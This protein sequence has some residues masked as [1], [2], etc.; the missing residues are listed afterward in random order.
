MTGRP[1]LIPRNAAA[2]RRMSTAN[3]A[4][5]QVSGNPVS[6]RLESGVGNCYPGLE[7]DL[8]NLER[9]FFP[10]LEVDI[11][12]RAIL[13]VA[14]DLPGVRG[15]EQAGRLSPEA[16]QA[17][18]RIATDLSAGVQWSVATLTG[19]FGELGDLTLRIAGLSGP[20][21]GPG[22]RPPDAWV[23]VR[24]LTEGSQVVLDLRR[25]AQRLRLAGARM[26]Y[27][28]DNGAL[29]P[30]FAPGELT[31][32]LCSPWT[33]DFRDCA[34]YYW[35]SNHPDIAR[36]PLPSPTPQK[37][38]WNDEVPWERRSRT[39]GALPSPATIDDP[40]EIN[41]YEINAD[42]QKLNFV[43]ERREIVGPYSAHEPAP[44]PPF[45]TPAEL[46]A[47][48]RYA[49]G[50]ELAVIQEYLT[51]AYSLRAPSGGPA[52]LRDDLRASFAELIRI[53][54]GEMHHLRAVNDLLRS[55]APAGAFRPALQVAT[56]I[57]G[58]DG[59]PRP[60]QARP[61]TIA[62][63][64]DFIDI[65]RP[66][67]SVDGLY[68]SV[69]ATLPPDADE[70]RQAVRTVMTEGEDHFETFSFIREWLGRHPQPQV[71]RSPLT[72]PPPTDAAHLHLQQRYRVLLEGLHDGYSVGVPAGAPSINAARTMMVE[73]DSIDAAA[74]AVA[75]RGFLVTFE[76]PA[77][78]RFT[79]I[80]KPS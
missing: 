54:I 63:I 21:M 44:A 43:V 15:L 3:P 40:D 16:V 29:A 46:E 74:R 24:M 51:A 77:D 48:L 60:V 55:L 14:V 18:D 69:L 11:A 36:P 28:D 38:E 2:F 50:V 79:P 72:M 31:Q 17:Y 66:S 25:G 59:N 30:M 13:V 56:T 8:R 52:E 47:H 53:A 75:D 78:P 10:F 58:A 26:R 7:C 42:W 80:P 41:Y 68:A 34:C 45:A 61:A 73:G 5:R 70:Q 62:V 32:S 35:A 39:L 37:P 71:L 64:D 27:L 67:V 20:S 49:A 23:A 19:T 6:T 65:E 1:K 33:H 4:I 57:P 9:R 76:A 12:D 22:R